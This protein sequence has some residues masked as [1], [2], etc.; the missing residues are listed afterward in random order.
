MVQ[1]INYKNLNLTTYTQPPVN[2]KNTIDKPQEYKVVPAT[3][4]VAE[5]TLMVKEVFD[6]PTGHRNLLWDMYDSLKKIEQVEVRPIFEEFIEALSGTSKNG[7]CIEEKSID[8]FMEYYYTAENETYTESTYKNSERTLL[9]KL[10]FG[11]RRIYNETPPE[12]WELSDVCVDT[13]L[14]RQLNIA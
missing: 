6:Y 14:R 12:I 7:T 8:G 10:L 1:T 5:L 3:C 2:Q 9:E 4:D 11:L 13:V